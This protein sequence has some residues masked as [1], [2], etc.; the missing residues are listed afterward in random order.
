MA[1]IEERTDDQVKVNGIV[2][3]AA[4][5]GLIWIKRIGFPFVATCEGNWKIGRKESPTSWK[6]L[7]G[8]HQRDGGT[9]G[10]EILERNFY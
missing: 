5:F 2:L 6:I 3:S 9:A 8:Y 4:F 10:C 7:G 1:Y